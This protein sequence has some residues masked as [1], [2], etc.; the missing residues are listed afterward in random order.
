MNKIAIIALIGAAS[1]M[2]VNYDGDAYYG[3]GNAGRGPKE[4]LDAFWHAAHT[5]STD[6]FHKTSAKQGAFIKAS[7]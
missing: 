3:D 4:T 1:T 5:S 6:E 7:H 2:E